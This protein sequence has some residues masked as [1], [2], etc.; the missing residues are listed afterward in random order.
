MSPHLRK[1]AKLSK[2]PKSREN[3]TNID[4]ILS[5]LAKPVDKHGTTLVHITYPPLI[6]T[7]RKIQKF[8]NKIDRSM[9]EVLEPKPYEKLS[10]M[11]LSVVE[12]MSLV[13]RV[14]ERTKLVK[15]KEIFELASRKYT[16]AMYKVIVQLED[17]VGDFVFV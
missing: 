12:G 2:W 8:T 16:K 11:E 15:A 17:Y 5:F 4:I 6:N 14:I 1:K 7:M 10:E 3:R 13:G 9:S